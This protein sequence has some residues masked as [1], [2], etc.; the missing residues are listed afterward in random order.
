MLQNLPYGLSS[1]PRNL[2]ES[3]AKYILNC[4]LACLAV[5]GWDFFKSSQGGY[6]LLEGNFILNLLGHKMKEVETLGDV[7]DFHYFE[8]IIDSGIQ[9]CTWDRSFIHGISSS[10]MALEKIEDM[11][12]ATTFNSIFLFLV[13][14]VLNWAQKIIGFLPFNYVID[15]LISILPHEISN[16]QITHFYSDIVFLY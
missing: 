13:S 3:K 5:H 15:Y 2:L 7:I 9:K 4:Q 10:Q 11:T 8:F 1:N 12:K 16:W 14:A 6:A